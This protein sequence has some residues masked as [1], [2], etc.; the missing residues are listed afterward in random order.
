VDAPQLTR[1]THARR[2]AIKRIAKKDFLNMCLSRGEYFL[3]NTIY[4][5]LPVQK[6]VETPIALAD[7][8]SVSIQTIQPGTHSRSR[9][10]RMN[11]NSGQA[12]N[13]PS[14][15]LSPT[16]VV[17][18]T[19]SPALTATRTYAP[20]EVLT[21]EV[22]K[23]KL[24][25]SSSTSSTSQNTKSSFTGN[26]LP[27]VLASVALLLGITGVALIRNWRKRSKLSLHR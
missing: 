18:P 8:S 14:V 15:P 24:V 3:K 6:V 4:P 2:N 5:S 11:A 17:S 16:S 12:A 26:T 27:L 22:R 23:N 7:R 19:H 13:A 20:G 25:I 10:H 21:P 1:R 9:I